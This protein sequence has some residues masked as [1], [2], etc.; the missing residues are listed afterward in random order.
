MRTRPL[1]TRTGALDLTVLGFGV[2]PLGNLYAAISEDAATAT[3][4]A[5]WDV[6]LRGFDTAPQYGVGLSEARF[7]RALASR[8]GDAFVLSTKIGRPLRGCR[9]GRA[10]PSHF[11]GPP[12][13]PFDYDYS[14]D[15]VMRSHEASL[16]RLGQD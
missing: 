16:E 6:G 13:R 12:N 5:A 7:G 8:P 10:P 14:Y 9:S 1:A 4:G 2:P 3:L 11:V 15:G